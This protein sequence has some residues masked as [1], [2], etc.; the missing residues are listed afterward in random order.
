[1]NKISSVL[2]LIIA[3]FVFACGKKDSTDT[4]TSN[5][6]GKTTTENK[7]T[8]SSDDGEGVQISYKM[9]GP[10]E[11]TMTMYRE[12]KNFR[13]DMKQSVMGQS[14]ENTMYSDGDYMYMLINMMG[15][16]QAMKMKM[17]QSAA[18]KPNSPND[19]DYYNL[20]KNLDKY[21]KVG[22]EKVLGKDCDIYKISEGTTISVHDK[23]YAMK[24]T[25]G[26]MVIEATEFKETDVPDDVLKIPT[27]VEF[28]EMDPKG[29]KNEVKD[30][31]KDM[32]K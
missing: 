13:T 3:L 29:L 30:N 8:P 6:E 1:M 32:K 4:T 11:G 19:I 2:L 14:M 25:S 18:G 7:E 15:Q 10:V 9:T 5:K 12:G 20:E 26:E 16:K 21:E 24:I 23:Q 27:N 28:K 17:D 22:S 31:M